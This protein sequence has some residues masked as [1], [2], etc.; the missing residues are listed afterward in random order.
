MHITTNRAIQATLYTLILTTSPGI[1]AD[2]GQGDTHPLT[3]SP[4]IATNGN[5][6]RYSPTYRLDESQLDEVRAGQVY[7]HCLPMGGGCDYI[8]TTGCNAT[9][10]TATPVIPGL[11]IACN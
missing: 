10:P 4:P 5:G 3:R 8:S 6:T 9:Y 11:I 1:S 7:A 2:R